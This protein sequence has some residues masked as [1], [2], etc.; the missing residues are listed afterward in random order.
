MVEVDLPFGLGIELDALYKRLNYRSDSGGVR[1]RRTTANSWE[2]PLLL[3]SRFGAGLA[4][5]YVAVGA[6]FNHLSGLTQ[7]GSF[8]SGT[9]R[10]AELQ[11]R[12][13]SGF[14]IGGGLELHAPLIRIS[15]E[16]RYT[17][18]GWENFRDVLGL[19]RSNQNQAEF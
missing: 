16:I 8:L 15:P 18:W 7:I 10:P 4:R 9:E 12:F 1:V 19:L 14:V 13:R 2:F 17:R 6:S 3:K 5:P 11:N